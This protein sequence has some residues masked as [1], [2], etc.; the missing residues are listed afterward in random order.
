M[1]GSLET[2]L[3]ARRDAGRALLVPYVTGGLTGDWLDYLRAYEDAGADAIEIGLPFS[4]PMLDG[5]TIQEA[6]DRALRRGVTP[7]GLLA[8]ISAAT[9]G[10]PL[11][12]M[13][14]SNLVFRA[15]ARRFC[16]RLAESGVSGLIVPD[17]QYDE[18]GALS[19]AATAAGVEL[20]LLAAPSTAPG[21]LRDIAGQSRGFVYGVTVMG[22]TGERADLAAS[23]RSVAT[24]LRELTTT[25]V[26]LG[27]GISRPEHAVEACGYA[28]GVVVAS[29]LMRRALD[30][31]T[32]AEVGA[33]V[34]NLRQ[35]LDFT[36]ARG[37]TESH[38]G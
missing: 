37:V 6:S 15:G 11:V 18:A 4:D 27:F 12:V 8:E 13:T 35:A 25:P 17:V 26:L 16:D 10:T 7:G 9:V 33:D 36:H 3:R 31:A 19:E 29:A 38:H 30:G 2:R 34:A 23:G 14:Y 1:I 32:P 28:D 5:G 21:R 24:R 20:T 22:T